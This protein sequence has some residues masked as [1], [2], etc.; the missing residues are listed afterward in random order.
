MTDT[1]FKEVGLVMKPKVKKPSPKEKQEAQSW[2][3]WEKEESFIGF[4]ELRAS[5]PRN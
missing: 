5:N 1:F 4:L 2:P 3:I